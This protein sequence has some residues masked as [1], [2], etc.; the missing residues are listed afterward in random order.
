MKTTS[1]VEFTIDLISRK[2]SQ[3]I[4]KFRKLHTVMRQ[5]GKTKNALPSKLFSS[6]QLRVKFFSKRVSFTEF[7]SKK[8]WERI[9][10][11]SKMESHRGSYR[12]LLSHC[13]DKDYVKATMALRSYWVD[14]TNYFWKER[15]SRFS[16]L[17]M[18]KWC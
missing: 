8:V 12:N 15:I 7:L 13:F 17:W 10:R 1:F 18:W 11:F 6:N 3:V 14:L 16:T 5:C 9:S 2:N 4:Q